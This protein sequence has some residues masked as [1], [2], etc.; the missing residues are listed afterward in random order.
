[1]MVEGMRRVLPHGGSDESFDRAVPF[2]RRLLEG[3]GA[4]LVLRSTV[5]G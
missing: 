5:N 1:M 4:V 3:F 2:A